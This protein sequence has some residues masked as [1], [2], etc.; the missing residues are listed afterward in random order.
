M[1]IKI[2]SKIGYLLQ[3]E[4]TTEVITKRSKKSADTYIGVA[5]YK[6]F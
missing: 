3:A 2:N 5:I 4:R 1:G 6:M